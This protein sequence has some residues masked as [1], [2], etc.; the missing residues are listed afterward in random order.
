MTHKTPVLW[1]VWDPDMPGRCSYILG[2]VSPLFS[3]D[4]DDF[5]NQASIFD[6]LSECDMLMTEYPNIC[7]DLADNV[8]DLG[9]ALSS[10]FSLQMSDYGIM[11]TITA[12]LRRCA[13]EHGMDCYSLDSMDYLASGK[14]LQAFENLKTP[15]NLAKYSLFAATSPVT[16]PCLT[17]F[18]FI[19]RESRKLD[20]I[21]AYRQ[22]NLNNL[23][24]ELKANPAKRQWWIRNRTKKW[25]EEG[26]DGDDYN[27]AH[28]GLP[29]LFCHHRAFVCVDAMHLYPGGGNLLRRLKK[30]GFKVKQ[31]R[32]LT[33]H[34]HKHHKHHHDGM[35]Q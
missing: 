30:L 18:K 4:L 17:I 9:K 34:R 5:F 13:F 15:S 2:S 3:D 10:F 19:A 8:N 27:P 6:C 14:M 25:I 28:R 24:D 26:Y 23:V 35:V 7:E 12:R 33:H 29:H 1:K 11:D 21:D 16:L 22:Q 20:N 32:L 31:Q